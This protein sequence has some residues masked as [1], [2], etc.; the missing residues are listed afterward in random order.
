[1]IRAIAVDDEPLA[2]DIIK[3]FCGK[4]DFIDLQ[5]TFTQPTEAIRYLKRFPVDLLFLDIRMPSISGLELLKSIPQE[6]MVIFTTA[7]R[8]FAVESY[9][10]QAIDYLLKPIEESRFLQ[11]VNR[12]K[13]Y[14][15]FKNQSSDGEKEKFIFIRADYS[16]VKIALQDILYIEGLGDYLKV[17]LQDKKTVV[18]RMTMKAMLDKLPATDFIR[19]HR[20]FI[21]PFGRI[22]SVRNKTIQVAG[23]S[24]PIGASFEESFMEKMSGR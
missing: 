22:E 8:E 20:S 3:E 12:A 18:V 14:F 2:L 10:L 21:I 19:V 1:M 13:D 9:E 5:R 15:D 7:H 23:E 11:A 24:I 17:H 16:L 4:T 6:V